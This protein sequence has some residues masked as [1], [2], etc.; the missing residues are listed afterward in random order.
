MQ[1][2]RYCRY[3]RLSRLRRGARGYRSGYVGRQRCHHLLRH[4]MTIEKVAVIG[5]GAM[6]APMA[7]NIHKAGFELVVCDRSDKARASFEALGVRSTSEA[8]DCADCDVVIILVATPDQVRA[9]VMGPGGLVSGVGD[10]KPMLVIMGTVAPQTMKDLAQELSGIGMRVVDAPV[11]GGVIKARE[12]TLAIIMGGAEEDCA[13]LQPLMEA[14]GSNI[15]R[16]GALGSGQAT[17][18]V[19]NMVGI[20]TLM[21]AAEAYRIGLENGLFLPDAMP[22]FEAGTG[23]NFLTSGP[24]DATQ[25]YAAWASTRSDF[26]SLHSILRK[27]IDLALSIGQN[28]GPLPMTNALREVLANVG[29]ETFENWLSVAQA[30]GSKS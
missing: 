12:G 8:A 29:D 14:M 5:V 3:G 2:A 11:S 10:K 20:S 28:A 19:N 27:D 1:A 24:G 23:R 9:A 16:C 4:D 30:P 6:G 25:A 15:F 22:V 21:I 26:D 7:M 13:Y 18:I 17:K